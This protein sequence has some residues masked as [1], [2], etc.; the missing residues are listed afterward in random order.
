MPTAQ[1]SLRSAFVNAVRRS[2]TRAP[3]GEDD[4]KIRATDDAVVVDIAVELRLAAAPRREQRRE[5]DAVDGVVA[6]D[7]AGAGV[8]FAGVRHA[9]LIGIRKLTRQDLA[10]VD[11]S[12][13]VAVGVELDEYFARATLTAVMDAI[14]LEPKPKLVR[15]TAAW[16]VWRPEDGRRRIR[17][18]RHPN[19]IRVGVAR[20]WSARPNWRR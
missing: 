5:V 13:V 3:A 6:G 19:P 15:L 2:R 20:R 11:D 17:F 9:V 12:V 14:P 16:I 10:V 1:A 18:A 4:C 8:D 7:I